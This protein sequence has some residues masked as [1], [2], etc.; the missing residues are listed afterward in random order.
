LPAASPVFIKGTPIPAGGD[1]LAMQ[2]N[3]Y[4]RPLAPPIGKTKH[5]S[6]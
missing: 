5:A 3:E 4:R 1:I 2:R 6:H